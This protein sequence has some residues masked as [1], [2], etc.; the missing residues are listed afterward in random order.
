[1]E[2]SFRLI[3]KW[4]VM[5]LS[6]ILLI[7]AL[8]HMINLILALLDSRAR[9]APSAIVACAMAIILSIC[10]FLGAY[11]D[12][13]LCLII[14]FVGMLVAIVLSSMSRLFYDAGMNVLYIICVGI[15]AFLV[16]ESGGTI[17]TT[18]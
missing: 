3:L 10:G 18:I 16:H 4:I 15:Y 6:A 1:M 12:H 17:T 5:I 2:I 9:V 13:L 11:K 7:Y 8:S 14:C